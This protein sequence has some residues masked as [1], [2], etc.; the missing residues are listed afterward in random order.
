MHMQGEAGIA[1]VMECAQRYYRAMVSGDEQALRGLF[2]SRI[3]IMG[4]FQGEFQWL[5]LD[6]FIDETKSLIGQHG[7]EECWIE[8]IR[9]DGSIAMAA[10]RGRY[11]GLMLVD[12]LMFVAVDEGW[13]IT[14]KSF[15]VV[16]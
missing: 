5:D 15:H 2:D 4:H 6:A 9:I 1:A 14:G 8:S 11:A 7:Q 12:H 10:V 3:A 13:L 16:E